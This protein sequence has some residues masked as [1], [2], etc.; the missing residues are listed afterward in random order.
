M[1]NSYIDFDRDDDNANDGSGESSKEVNIQ[2][3]YQMKQTYNVT[4]Q[5]ELL[6]KINVQQYST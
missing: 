5:P 6:V 2:D 4:E 1:F 3:M